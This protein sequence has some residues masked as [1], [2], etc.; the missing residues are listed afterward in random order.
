MKIVN[1]WLMPAPSTLLGDRPLAFASEA[2]V[3]DEMAERGTAKLLA[4][5]GSVRR[6]M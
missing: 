6:R 4:K 1:L 3:R 5:D 2:E